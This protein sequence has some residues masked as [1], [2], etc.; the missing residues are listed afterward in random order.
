MIDGQRGGQMDEHQPTFDQKNP[1]KRK[2]QLN[3]KNKKIN[4]TR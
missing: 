1:I 3:Q 4:H 2:A